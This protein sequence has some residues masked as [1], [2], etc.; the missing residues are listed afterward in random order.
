LE[1]TKLFRFQVDWNIARRNCVQ[2]AK[3]HHSTR[4]LFETETVLP[5]ILQ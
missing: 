3:T 5:V 4:R 1:S 2:W